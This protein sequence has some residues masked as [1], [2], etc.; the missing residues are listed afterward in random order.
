MFSSILLKQ[1]LNWQ[2]LEVDL[3][4]VQTRSKEKNQAADAVI[5]IRS[6]ESL[7]SSCGRDRIIA[8]LLR[9]KGN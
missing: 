5:E 2:M 4:S 6:K 3:D 7:T 1:K 8:L 9:T